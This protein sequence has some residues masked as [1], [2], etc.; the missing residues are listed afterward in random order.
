MHSL[1]LGLVLQFCSKHHCI[2][3]SRLTNIYQS[4][5]NKVRGTDAAKDVKWWSMQYGSGMPKKWPE[6][7]VSF[8]CTVD[9]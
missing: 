7:E 5:L 9:F 1:I 6:F 3:C 4:L 8:S 2:S